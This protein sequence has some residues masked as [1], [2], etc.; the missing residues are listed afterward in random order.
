MSARS[1]SWSGRSRGSEHRAAVAAAFA[2]V[3]LFV[4]CFALLH[5]G[6]LGRNQ[7]IDTPV[8]ERYGN[9]IVDGGLVPYR[10]FSLEYPPGALPV[11]ALP[12][13]GPPEDYRTLFE[14]LMALCGVATVVLVVATLAALGAGPARLAGAAAFVGLSPLALGS[15]VLTRF[16][17]WPAALTAGALAAFVSGR[18]R[19]GAGV[20][21]AAVAA[22]IYPV[23]L[24]PVLLLWV[25]KRRGWREA[26]V[27]GGVF[28]LVLVVIVLPLAILA[29]DGI[30]ESF[31]R[32]LSRPLQI[33]SLGAAFLLVAHTFDGDYV[34][35]VVSSFGSQNLAGGAA[36]ALATLQTVL[37][38]LAVVGVWV[39]FARTRRSEEQ[40]VVACA[41]A[42]A[43]FVAFGKVVSPQFLIW[44]CPLVP[45]VAGRRGLYG[46]ALLLVAL[47]LTHLW[48]PSRYW[49]LVGLEAGPAWL[50][51]MR[52]LALVALV[53]LLA[54]TIPRVSARARSG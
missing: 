24:L 42:A 16:D 17:L 45:L 41:A 36:D 6:P 31:D 30:L 11:F 14:L 29:P 2:G 10:D 44:L 5:V 23:V 48:F 54:T 19:L 18:H 26:G 40:L 1:E 38:A 39:L 46:S 20:L 8:Y 21:G 43:A 9:A 37:Q 35:Q 50:L 52:D 15:V 13:L 47:V 25:A 34:P 22:K 4:G 12:A 7:I 27:C 49:D 3:I 32:Q 33:E 51:T 53:V 28:L